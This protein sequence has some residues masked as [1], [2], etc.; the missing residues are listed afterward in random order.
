VAA[1]AATAHHRRASVVLGPSGL[2]AIVKASE[3]LNNQANQTLST[4]VQNENETG[5]AAQIDDALFEFDADAGDH[6]LGGPTYK[7]FYPEIV[8]GAVP[9]QT[10]YPAHFLTVLKDTKVVE[11]PSK[12]SGGGYLYDYEK[13]SATASWKVDD[14]PIID[15]GVVPALASTTGG[16]GAF[17][18]SGK[19]L[20]TDPASIPTTLSDDIEAYVTG[21]DVGTASTI[22]G[23][24]GQC[25]SLPTFTFKSSFTSANKQGYQTTYKRLTTPA[26]LVAYRTANGGAV[27]LFTLGEALTIVPPAGDYTPIT[28]TPGNPAS[29]Q[30]PAG[31]YSSLTYSYLQEVAVEI[32]S[33]K[34]RTSAPFKVIGI[35]GGALAGS[36]TPYVA[37]VA[38]TAAPGTTAVTPTSAVA[39]AV[40]PTSTPALPTVTITTTPT[41]GPSVQF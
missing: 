33:A 27:A 2:A 10:S 5:S 30:V 31:D 23:A 15:V 39:P 25:W 12:C 6:S 26:D 20:R 21:S 40:T 8:R 7:P 32:P 34:T 24:K 38:P 1:A 3:A 17:A 37:P 4:A 22:T 13:S 16:Y 41:G 9:H 14:E 29:F 36:G 19:G 28:S 35:D 11:A 18:T